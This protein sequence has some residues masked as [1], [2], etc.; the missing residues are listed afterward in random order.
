MI[1]DASKFIHL[2][3][4]D[5]GMVTFGNNDEARVI[6]KIGTKIQNV[7]HVQGLIHNL[8]S[9]SQFCDEGQNVKFEKD[10]CKVLDKEGSS[11]VLLVLIRNNVYVVYMND[12]DKDFELCLFT[13]KDECVM[14]EK[15]LRHINTKH[16]VKIANQKMVSKLPKLTL[17]KDMFYNACSLVK[18][19][20]TSFKSKTIISM[21]F[22]LQLLYLDLFG[23]KRYGLVVVDD[24]SGYTWVLFLANKDEAFH[25][26]KNF[27]KKLQNEE[28]AI[29]PL[30][31]LTMA[32]SLK[33]IC[34]K[35]STMSISLVT[36]SPYLRPMTN[37]TCNEIFKG[38]K[39]N[40]SY[41]H[42]F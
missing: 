15:H 30:L 42:M 31:A 34:L 28:V 29:L 14:W 24:F 38:R 8:L 6:D 5:G 2:K 40:L 1:G 41:F 11:E 3:Y 22:P 16:L 36:T 32:K 35:H 19:V 7:L 4:E 33:I 13:V 9:I 18:H 17:S 26:F 23:K 27:A 25:T 12:L 10:M 20:R 39:P 37:K 21:T